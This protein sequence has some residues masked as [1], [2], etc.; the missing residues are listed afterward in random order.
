MAV[1]IGLVGFVCFCNGVVETDVEAYEEGEYFF[2]KWK[3]CLSR[4]DYLIGKIGMSIFYFIPTIHAS[5]SKVRYKMNL[6]C[7]EKESC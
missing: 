6:R 7:E 3:V 1:L 5:I 2:Q 4:Q